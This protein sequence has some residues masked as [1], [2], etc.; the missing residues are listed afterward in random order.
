MIYI[1]TDG[2]FTKI[3]KSKNPL[4]R[5]KNLQTSNAKTLKFQYVFDVP[6]SVE[7]RLHNLF[8]N[9]KTNANNEWF[10]I[11]NIII[12]TKLKSIS[13][14]AL[15]DI[16]LA[17]FKAKK[18]NNELFRGEIHTTKEQQTT[19]KKL[20]RNYSD[21]NYIKQQ[22]KYL[23]DEMKQHLKNKKNVRISYDYYIKKYKFSKEEISFYMK[24]CGLS[25]DIF[26]HNSRL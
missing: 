8:K 2:M 14:T 7:K 4:S 23:I 26:N 10:Q 13:I 3:G 20:Y 18:L 22:R 9:Y 21:N 11:D 17:L 12:E 19:Y 25:K 5:I 16:D 15:W 24:S 1:I 6:D